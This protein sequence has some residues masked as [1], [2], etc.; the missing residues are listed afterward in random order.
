MVTLG[1]MLSV[2]KV[3]WALLYCKEAE[4][5]YLYMSLY[6]DLL[7]ERVQ[8]KI[9]N[10]QLY[11]SKHKSF[12]WTRWGKSLLSSFIARYCINRD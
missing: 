10:G 4:M 7:I 3:H 6:C 11:Y 5:T 9:V 1:F 2:S 12:S 8:Y